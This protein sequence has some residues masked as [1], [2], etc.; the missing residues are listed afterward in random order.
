LKAFL[1]FD[2]NPQGQI[3]YGARG[4]KGGKQ[5]LRSSA[6]PEQEKRICS[7]TA[8]RFSSSSPT[9]VQ[10]CAIPART[11][12]LPKA[13]GHHPDTQERLHDFEMAAP[14]PFGSQGH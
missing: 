9:F 11:N 5:R 13:S 6:K 10:I 3:G 2:V 8:A 7:A 12:K 4:S 1:S 14:V